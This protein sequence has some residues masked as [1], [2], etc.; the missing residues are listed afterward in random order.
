MFPEYRELISKLKSSDVHFQKKFD[1]HNDLDAEIRKLEKHHASD[2]SAEV[3]DLKKQKLKLKEE[4]YDILK[5]H[6]H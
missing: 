1:L 5:Q 2:Y 4:I 3:R 6:P